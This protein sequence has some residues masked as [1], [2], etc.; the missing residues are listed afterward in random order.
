MA[1][2]R[3]YSNKGFAITDYSDIN[4]EDVIVSETGSLVTL[5]D[6]ENVKAII[7]LAPGERLDR[8]KD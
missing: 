5:T 7:H 4:A 6:T 2:F 8:I 3:Y 1:T